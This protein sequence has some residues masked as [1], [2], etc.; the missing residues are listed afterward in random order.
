MSLQIR[1][2]TNAERLTA[3]FAEGEPIY[4]TDTQQLFIGD[5]MNPTGVLISPGQPVGPTDNPAFNNTTVT[6]TLTVTTLKSSS[7]G[8][9]ITSRDELLGYT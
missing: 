3:S 4:T 9:A 8:I 6:N 7:D 1:R 5:S 2:G